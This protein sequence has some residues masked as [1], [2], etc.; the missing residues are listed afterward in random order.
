VASGDWT[1]P[2]VWS[3]GVV[4]TADAR[5]VISSGTTVRFNAY[6]NTAIDTLRIDGKLQFAT[7]INTQLKVDTV[8]V[9]T[10]GVLHIGTAAD[11]VQNNVTARVLIADGGPIDVTKDPYK[12]GRGIVSRGEVKMYGMAVTPYVTLA[13]QP[14]AGD[15]RLFL[16]SIP[17]NWRVGDRLVVTGT[18]PTRDDFGA[19]EVTIL[20]INGTVV[21][22]TAMQFSHHTPPNSGLSVHVANLNRNVVLTAEDSSVV[23][24][25]PHMVFFHNP[26]VSIDNIG[27][28]GFGRTDKSIPINDPVV[29]NGVLQPG[30]GTN[31]RARY[32]IHFH[33]TGVNPAYAP[34]TVRGSVVEGS[35]GWG[36]VNHSSNVDFINNVA[37]GVNGSAF[38]TEDGNEIG[39][40]V[41]NLA[42]STTGAFGGIGSRITIHDFGF[43][44]HGFWFQGPGID[45]V[46][47]ISAGS[48]SGGFAYF[49][50]SAKNL[51]DAVNLSDPALAGGK[52]AVPVDS[53]PLKGFSGN[54]AYAGRVGLEIWHSMFRM[55]DGQSY[56]DNFTSWNTAVSGIETFYSGRITVRNSTLIGNLSSPSGVGV[57]TNHFTQDITFQN[58]RAIG[59]SV[60]II[61][62]VRGATIVDGGYF[63]AVQGVYIEKGYDTR[64]VVD[65]R[66]AVTFAALSPAQ[67]MGRRQYSVYLSLDVDYTDRALASPDS[68]FTAETILLRPTGS[69]VYRLYYFLQFKGV[70]PFTP[71]AT[72]ALPAGFVNLKNWQLQLLHGKVFGGEMV[73]NYDSFGLP[74]VYGMVRKIG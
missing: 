50:S 35:P 62:P 14:T 51:F 69:P 42:V 70:T 3:N 61:A 72:A 23:A 9:T 10:T 30:T 46:D 2:A 54:T 63:A 37:Y 31:P 17:A 27:V 40:M 66:G 45:V 53:V 34:A 15:T 25:R 41:R 59:L 8:V 33:H 39:S 21:T 64:R 28:Y 47:N 58:L 22:T 55:T 1:N 67:L 5:V 38:V 56:I 13:L 73:T 26:N 36:Y 74:T 71:A 43:Q 65:I 60:G 20:A 48:Y 16:S 29:V 68:L 24:E 12:L 57:F 44:G 18:M 49:T 32:A 52:E 7:N 4:P 11:P 6:M 19:D